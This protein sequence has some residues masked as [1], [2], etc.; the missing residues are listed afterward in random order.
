MKISSIRTFLILCIAPSFLSVRS[1]VATAV[2]YYFRGH[3]TSVLETVTGNV[4]AFGSMPVGTELYGSCT[5][6]TPNNSPLTY[7]SYFEI[8]MGANKFIVGPNTN[9]VDL[10][11]TGAPGGDPSVFITV[12]NGATDT[13]SLTTGAHIGA[14]GGQSLGGFNDIGAVLQLT[15]S[16]GTASP[17]ANT[18][19]TNLD[20]S[21]FN[22]AQVV[23]TES[24]YY[25]YLL[26]GT[27]P[28]WQKGTVT[29]DYFSTTPI[30]EPSGVL[31]S[32]AST[33]LACLRR[34]R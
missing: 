15:D 20:I 27:S 7:Y 16:I 6:Y 5:Y 18:T 4:G 28:G 23:L 30:P 31:L 22:L 17:A 33:E 2:T 34:R 25:N 12:G 8:G 9:Y 26:N 24:G 3:I 14:L 19:G 11:T 21:N 13:L 1:E 32:V 29:L 10:P